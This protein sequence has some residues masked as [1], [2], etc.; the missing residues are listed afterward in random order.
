MPPKTPSQAPVLP[1]HG[2]LL[3]ER[4]GQ[5]LLDILNIIVSAIFG[6]R[7]YSESNMAGSLALQE[8]PTAYTIASGV[9]DLTITG[10]GGQD[11]GT[12]MSIIIDTEGA[13]ATDDLDTISGTRDGM[14]IIPRAANSARTVV[15]KNGTG[16]LFMQADFSLNNTL[17]AIMLQSRNGVLVE[18]SRSD[19][20]A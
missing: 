1:P 12:P 16:N 7:T 18:L 6:G 15:L 10:H 19:N 20:G 11:T 3:L 5:T 8:Y 14:I 9:I 13:A 17:D 2:R 4:E